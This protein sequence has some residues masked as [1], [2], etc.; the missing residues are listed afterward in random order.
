M[1]SQTKASTG[2]YSL[3]KTSLRECRAT[4]KEG[5]FKAVVRR[6]GWKLFAVFFAYYLIRDAILYLLIP[7]L[8]AQH[9][10]H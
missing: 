7:Y 4:F 3:A 6:Y 1:M 2:W 10:I 5:G 9:F 8:V